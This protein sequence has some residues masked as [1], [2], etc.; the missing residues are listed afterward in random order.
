MIHIRPKRFPSGTAKKL[1]ARSAGPFKVLKWI[2]SNAYVIELPYDY[3]IS[4][5]FNIVDLVAYKGPTTILDEPF[6]MIH[7]LT[8]LP[9]PLALTLT[10]SPP[11]CHPHIKNLL[12]LF[13][14]SR[15]FSLG[16]EQF[17]VS[18]FDGT[19]D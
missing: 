19:D 17:S 10:P 13:W 5:T 4:S 15:L 2:G 6:L 3:G 14:M 9:P 11:T 16:M 1:Q 18:W 8:P 7:L 12:M